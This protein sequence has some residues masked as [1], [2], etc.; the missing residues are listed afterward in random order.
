MNSHMFPEIETVFLM[1][2]ERWFYVSASRVRELVRF[3]A[4][5]TRVRAGRGRRET[6]RAHRAEAALSRCAA[7]SLALDLQLLHLE[8]QAAAR[9]AEPCAARVTLPSVR[10]RASRMASRSMRC[11]AERMRSRSGVALGRR[12]RRARRGGEL[13]RAGRAARA[14]CRRT[15]SDRALD[16]VLE[17]ADVAR[18]VVRAQRVERGGVDARRPA[19]CSFAREALDEAGAPGSG[20]P[21]AARAAAAAS[22]GT[23][24]RR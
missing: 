7:Q 11:V 22:I 19:R 21:R 4:D 14:S 16:R 10:R 9:E 23:T 18:P 17:L 13:G 8:L 2:S 24:F 1:T 15:S 3:G 12:A 6:A 20:C 5:V